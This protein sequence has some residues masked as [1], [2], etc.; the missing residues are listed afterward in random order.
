MGES[1]DTP[2]RGKDLHEHHGR[3]CQS[4]RKDSVLVALTLYAEAEVLPMDPVE[5]YVKVGI[6]EVQ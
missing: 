3:G 6:L 1:S 4:K 2:K 5:Q